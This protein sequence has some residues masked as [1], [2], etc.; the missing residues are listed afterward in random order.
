MT[1]DETFGE[2]KTCAKQMDSRY[3][4]TVFDEWAIVSLMENKARVLAYIGPRNDQ[5]LEN[6]VK[7]LG[8]LRAELHTGTYGVGDFEFERH[9][10]G[11]DHEVFMVLGPGLYLICNNT[12]ESMDAIAK[13]PRWLEAQVPFAELSEKIR[14][15]HLT[16]SGDNTK[17]L[18]KN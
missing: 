2:I 12:Q 10:V 4:K 9:G 17:F 18:K 16:I 7:D 15:N 13:N 11:T 8:K 6:F 3:G 14:A 1:L 5:F